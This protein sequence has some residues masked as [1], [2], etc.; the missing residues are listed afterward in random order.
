MVVDVSLIEKPYID[1]NIFKGGDRVEK[2]PYG[3]SCMPFMQKGSYPEHRER[4]QR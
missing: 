3:Y 2:E 4:G 1:C